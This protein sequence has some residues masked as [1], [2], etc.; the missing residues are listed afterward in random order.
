MFLIIIDS[1]SRQFSTSLTENLQ[2]TKTCEISAEGALIDEE[3]KDSRNRVK[4]Q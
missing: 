4:A 2:T 1:C 3:V